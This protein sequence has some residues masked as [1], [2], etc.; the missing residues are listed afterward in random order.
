MMALRDIISHRKCECKYIVLYT[1]LCKHTANQE[2]KK[3]KLR[4]SLDGIVEINTPAQR[5]A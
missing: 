1:E 5:D 2:K 3:E 4:T